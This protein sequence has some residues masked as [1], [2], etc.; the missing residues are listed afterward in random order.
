VHPILLSDGRLL[1][2]E[3]PQHGGE[4]PDWVEVDADHP[5]YRQ[6]LAEAK[7]GKDPRP[8]SDM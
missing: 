1:I 2:Q 6:W 8:Q 4:P 3:E 7:P 5:D